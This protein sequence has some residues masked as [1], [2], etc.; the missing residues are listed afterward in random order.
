M[1]HLF[2]ELP[3]PK[4]KRDRELRD[5]NGFFIRLN[6]RPRRPHT[7][8]VQLQDG[9]KQKIVDVLIALN[10]ARRSAD[11]LRDGRSLN[12][13][14]NLRTLGECYEI[15]RDTK[16]L[17]RDSTRE[18]KAKSTLREAERVTSLFAKDWLEDPKR[19]SR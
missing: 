5:T 17:S 3:V 7:Y 18:R 1:E 8:N 4:A 12:D 6:S 9:S 13:S 10:E 2:G 19:Q 16:L 15:W 14:P 11:L